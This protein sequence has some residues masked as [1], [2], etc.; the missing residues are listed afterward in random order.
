MAHKILYTASTYSHLHH[1][2]LPYIRAFRALGWEVD[3]ACGGAPCELPG[4]RRVIPLPFQKKMSS[5]KNFFAAK[6]L[7][8]V[9]SGE[10]YDLIS[11]H[12]SLAAFFTRL[13]VRGMRDRPTVVNTA[14][15][16][17]FD[18][19]TPA[20]KRNV[21][22][23]AERLTA[24]QT[25]LLMTMNEWDYQTALR[26]RLGGQVVSIPGIG[27]DFSRLSQ[28]EGQDGLASAV[29]R[30]LGVGGEDFLLI[31]AAEF[32]K[33]KSQEVLLRAMAMLPGHIKLVLAGEGALLEECRA[34]A[35]SLGLEGRV[36]FP[37]Y[38]SNMP[39]WYRAADA[40]V[41]ASRSEG[42]PFNIMEAMYLR[43]PVVASAVKGHTDLIQ[44]GVTGLL[45]PYGDAAACARS[46]TRLS[47]DPGA[48]AALAEAARV[49]VQPYGIE[50]VL[51]K[52][53]ELY[54]S[55]CPALR[56]PAFSPAAP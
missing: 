20:L 48:A 7:R 6:E 10:H 14:H 33:R 9:I 45:Y 44:D 54:A 15:G 51:P 5:P 27:V 13:A 55:C 37:G 12:T 36:F 29:R 38:L 3:A 8:R 11:T 18:A 34:L 56:E 46:I 50:S 1:F 32:S 35:R 47:E 40:A 30:E 4:V 42:L 23:G 21:L 31:Y 43:R 41:S 17:L 25:D 24:P 52:V 28:G 49:S 22:L 2:H 26:H 39:L 16:Y 53:M 19:R